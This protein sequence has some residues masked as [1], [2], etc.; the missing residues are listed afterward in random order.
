MSCLK[1]TLERCL[2]R[3]LMASCETCPRPEAA[4]CRSAVFVS[5]LTRQGHHVERMVELTVSTRRPPSKLS[6]PSPEEMESSPSIPIARR[7]SRAG[8]CRL[9]LVPAQEE[10]A[11]ASTSRW[12]SRRH[13]GRRYRARAWDDC[14][15]RSPGDRPRRSGSHRSPATARRTQDPKTAVDV[16]GEN[17]PLMGPHPPDERGT[18]WEVAHRPGR[19]RGDKIAFLLGVFG[20]REVDPPDPSEYQAANT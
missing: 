14:G 20:I 16:A 3:H 18:G 15:A 6:F 17:E 5:S 8:D 10:T 7:P 13:A 11:G 9:R 19:R 4:P 12:A 1:T 2:L